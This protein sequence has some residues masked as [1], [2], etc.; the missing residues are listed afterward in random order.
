MRYL[1]VFILLWCACVGQAAATVQQDHAALT[2]L[3]NTFLDGATRNDAQV[4]QQ[5][6][7]DELVYTSSAGLRFG[8]AELM[9]GVKSRGEIAAEA[10]N[11]RYSSEQVQIQL[12]GDTAVV[13]FV[14]VG[15]SPSETLRFYNSGTFVK[16]DGNWQAVNW[17]ATRQATP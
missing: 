8:K 4:H 13:T 1:F 10:I 6:W 12:Y 7:A 2:A 16:R 3:L 17:Q 11:M 9:Q 5:F 15:S 14:L